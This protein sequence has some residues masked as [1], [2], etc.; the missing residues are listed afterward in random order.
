MRNWSNY[1]YYGAS[2]NNSQQM[3]PT[4]GVGQFP[5]PLLWIPCHQ[6]MVELPRTLTVE[7]SSRRAD[8]RRAFAEK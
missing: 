1:K 7:Q 3:H 4:S 8:E 2:G 5:Y 6:T